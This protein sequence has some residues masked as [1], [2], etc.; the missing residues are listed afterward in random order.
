MRKLE[1]G[2]AEW[3]KRGMG[4][5]QLQER[6]GMNL[7]LRCWGGGEPVGLG[8]ASA[9]ELRAGPGNLHRAKIWYAGDKTACKGY[10][11]S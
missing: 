11:P 6:C 2:E 1:L 9:G 5:H 3:R 4:S 7:L 8:A 10:L